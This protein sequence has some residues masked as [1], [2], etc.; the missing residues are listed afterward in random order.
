MAE[1]F[2]N[3][4]GTIQSRGA[5]IKRIR[6]LYSK[7]DE[8]KIYQQAIE[9]LSERFP[10][11]VKSE[12]LAALLERGR[13]FLADYSESASHRGECYGVTLDV[14][15]KFPLVQGKIDLTMLHELIHK[16]TFAKKIIDEKDFE[17]NAPFYEGATELAA[18]KVFGFR[19]ESSSV[20][21]FQVNLGGDVAYTVQVSL[22][23]QLDLILGGDFVERSILSDKDAFKNENIRRY[24]HRRI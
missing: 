6:K 14:S 17:K 7:K 18:Q 3:F 13:I 15:T 9:L 22:L 8:E 20:S 16:L 10:E 24:F 11:D 1:D 21:G 5:K 23:K 12:D 4:E 19:K 2:E